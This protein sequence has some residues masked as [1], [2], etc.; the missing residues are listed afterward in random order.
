MFCLVGERWG[1]VGCLATLLI[2]LVLFA[3]GLMIAAGTR[4][5]YGRLLAVGIVVLLGTQMLINTGMTVGLMPITGMTL[6]LMSYGGS[7]LLATCVALGLLINISM[8]PG[9]EV[10]HDPFVF[11]KAEI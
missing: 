2:Y 8:R 9:Y 4:E 11:S 5:P 1:A 3:R 6:P 10:A 7:S